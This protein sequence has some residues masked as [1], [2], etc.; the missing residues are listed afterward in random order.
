MGKRFS[1][2]RIFIHHSASPKSTTKEQIRDW[3]VGGN[4]WSDIGYHFIINGATG[5]IFRARPEE[6][7][8][9]HAKDNNSDSIG[10][11]ITGDY[12][13]ENVD[14]LAGMSLY[15]LVLGLQIKYGLTWKDVYYH[16]EVKPTAC[17]GKNLAH[18]IDNWRLHG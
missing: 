2:K 14:T 8:G 1:T 12:E 3:H 11:C 4:G 5:D 16:K 18:I 9:A 17:P 10:I 15:I 7:I 6:L 13:V